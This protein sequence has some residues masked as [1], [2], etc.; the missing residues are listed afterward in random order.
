MKKYSI[1]IKSFFAAAISIFMCYLCIT[2]TPAC[3]HFL[4]SAKN[5]IIKGGNISSDIHSF[6]TSAINEMAL[7]R[8]WLGLLW[9]AAKGNWKT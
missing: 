4:L 9:L 7:N 3:F 5:T 2:L 6:S 8:V 1:I